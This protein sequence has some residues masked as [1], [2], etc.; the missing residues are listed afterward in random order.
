VSPREREARREEG[1]SA[2]ALAAQYLDAARAALAAE[3]WNVAASNAAV[4]GVNACDAITIFVVG[5]Y[6]QGDS[7]EQALRLLAHA[8][9]AGIAAVPT[10]KRL[11]PLKNR[12][13]YDRRP[14]SP[15][16]ATHAVRW[17]ERLVELAQDARAGG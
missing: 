2:L 17:A 12:A 6:S 8:G 10:F 15:V 9:P 16:S 14:L 7:H 4:A 11:E 13:Q 1:V 3:Q 5:R